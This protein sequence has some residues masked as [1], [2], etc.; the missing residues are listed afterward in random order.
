MA[1]SLLFVGCSKSEEPVQAE[2]RRPV[3]TVLVEAPDIGGVR[4]FPARIDALNKAE[5]AF[6]V[7]GTVQE[8]LV[9]EG[10]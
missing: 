1:L 4:R 9:K 10:D 6:R 3:K 2:T 8:L 5:L 7:P